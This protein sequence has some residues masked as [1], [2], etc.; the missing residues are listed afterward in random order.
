MRSAV[1]ICLAAPKRR[2]RRKSC[3]S[4]W[5]PRPLAAPH[6]GDFNARGRQSR[7]CAI[8]RCAPNLRRTR[9]AAQKGRW[10]TVTARRSVCPSAAP[11]SFLSTQGIK[12]TTPNGV[13][14]FIYRGN[15]KCLAEVNSAC[16]RFS[17]AA[18]MFVRRTR[19]AGQKAGLSFGGGSIFDWH[20]AGNPV[21]P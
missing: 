20:R 4:F 13:V 10:I 15:L 3:P 2:T 18:K 16:A 17:P 9:G 8:L 6:S 1:R 12:I 5:A 11:A 21:I 19:A 7:P 14:I